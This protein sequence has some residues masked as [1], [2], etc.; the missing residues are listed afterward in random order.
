MV[1]LPYGTY[2]MLSRQLWHI[3]F[4]KLLIDQQL[5]QKVCLIKYQK[6]INNIKRKL[7]KSSTFLSYK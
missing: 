2:S 5:I 7:I 6:Y 3:S 1:C 4:L